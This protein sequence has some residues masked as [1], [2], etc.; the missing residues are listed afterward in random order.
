MN[1][2]DDSTFTMPLTLQA[3]QIAEQ[4]RIQQSNPQRAKQVYLNTLAVQ[5]VHHYLAWLGIATDLAAGDSWNPVMQSL[6]DVADLVIPDRGKLECRPVLPQAQVCYVP[7]E[8]WSDRIGYVAVQF[9][10][11][12]T[13]ATLL[14]VVPAVQTS[15]V[16]LTALRSLDELLDYVN[17]QFVESVSDLNRTSAAADQSLAGGMTQLDRW[18]EG[19]IV[20]GWQAIEPFWAGQHPAWSMRGA[21]LETSDLLLNSSPDLSL[22]L[23]PDLSPDLSSH[24]SPDPLLTPSFNLASAEADQFAATEINRA[25]PL[26]LGTEPTEAIILIV[27]VLPTGSHERVIWVRVAPTPGVDHLPTALEV[28]I[29][30]AT[31]SV[32]MQAQSRQTEMIQLR[33]MG[34]VGEQFAVRLILAA[35]QVTEAFVI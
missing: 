4:F 19:V 17:P 5:A 28:L 18:L 23:S 33:F 12:L 9:D 26:V 30:D 15:E 20:A 13:E 25:K 24:L 14:G 34:E 35:E 2:T 10:P 31:G 8:V 6:A 21:E 27:G 16:S 1:R 32:V 11:D 3:H 22:D 7:A 29:L